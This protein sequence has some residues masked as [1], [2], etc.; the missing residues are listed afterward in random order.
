MTTKQQESSL[1]VTPKSSNVNNTNKAHPV[2]PPVKPH[3][4]TLTE[5]Y[6]PNV[7]EIKNWGK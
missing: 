4:R 5:S 1:P 6:I 2:A 7:K 3:N